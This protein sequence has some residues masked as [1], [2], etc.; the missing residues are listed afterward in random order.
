MRWNRLSL[1]PDGMV[2]SRRGR[3][4][5]V[6]AMRFT[7]AEQ[8]EADWPEVWAT[9]KAVFREGR[10]Y[11]LP[12]DVSEQGAKSY[13][14]KRDGFNGVARDKTGQMLGAYFLRPDQGG[15]GDHVC[16]AG[17]VIA[18]AARGRGLAT[19]LCLQ[20]QDQ[21]RAMGFRAMVFNFVVA[22]NEAAIRAW[23]R[24][25]L[26]IIGTKP[27]AFRMPDGSYADAHIMWKAL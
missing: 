2:A 22:E 9:L 19:P 24:A 12:R 5:H 4:H 16:N 17:Y 23:A 7:V 27:G 1:T 25:G 11:P 6:A 10:T 26:K 8:A 3:A 14:I 13:W 15:P 18:A 20:S 21:A